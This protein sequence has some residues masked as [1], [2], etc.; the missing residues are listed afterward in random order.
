MS[1]PPNPP[2]DR[3]Q[4]EDALVRAYGVVMSGEEVATVLKLGSAQALNSARWRGAITLTPL[5]IQGRRAHV[6]GPSEVAEV[7]GTWLQSVPEEDP[8]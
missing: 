2:A 1:T 8:S 5:R 4:I 7:L 6:Y 3:Q